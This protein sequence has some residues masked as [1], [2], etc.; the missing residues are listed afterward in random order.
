[1]ALADAPVRRYPPC[2]REFRATRSSGRRPLSSIDLIVMHDEEASTA[3]SAAAFFASGN[4]EGSAHLCVD[5]KECYRTLPDGEIPWAAPGANSQGLHIEQAGF[6]RW[7]IVIWRSHFK[8]LDRAAFKAA[9]WCHKY[10]VPAQFLSASALRAGRRGITT[11]R[12]VSLWQ[13]SIGAPG[14]H[15]HSD[16]GPFWPRRLFMR[17]VRKHLAAMKG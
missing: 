1:M 13:A 6:A 3:R 17:R 5:D 8:T 15:S 2:S 10:G 11:H 4:A 12:Q 9:Q 7:S 14:D 16:P